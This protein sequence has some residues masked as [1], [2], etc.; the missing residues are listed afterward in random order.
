M[1]RLDPY[2]VLGVKKTASQEEIKS[3]YR[4][5]ALKYHPDRNQGDS[6]AEEKF[7]NVSSAYSM[8]GD[9]E[10]KRQYDESTNPHRRRSRPPNFDDVFRTV[11]A[12]F[13]FGNHNGPSQHQG[14]WEDLFGSF[15]SQHRRP[16]S[17][18]ARIDVTLEDLV[19]GVDK[20]FILDNNSVSFKIPREARHDMT[21]V[22]PMEQ[23]GQELHATLNVL[24]HPRFV[25]DGDDL[26]CSVNVPVSTAIMGGELDVETLENNVRLKIGQFTG[27]HKKLR[28]KNY[29]LYRKDGT[30]GSIIYELKLTFENMSEIEKRALVNYFS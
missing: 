9:P 27:S 3:A 17:I 14:S 8:I 29:G 5:K 15:Q 10:S 2:T 4:K 24:R 18:K 6:T 26:R 7:K 11:N 16:F 30:R 28:V 22:V 21:V 23:N 25:V 1:Q 19:R 20:T 12:N 13:N